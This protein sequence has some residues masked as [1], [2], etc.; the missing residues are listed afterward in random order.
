MNKTIKID[1]VKIGTVDFVAM[2]KH[3]SYVMIY[4]IDNSYVEVKKEDFLKADK[5]KILNFENSQITNY[6]DL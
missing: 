4:L 3:I 6:N 2:R 1:N 5:N